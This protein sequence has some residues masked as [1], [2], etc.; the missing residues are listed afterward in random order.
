MMEHMRNLKRWGLEGRQAQMSWVEGAE[1]RRSGKGIGLTL[2][3]AGR[4][5]CGQKEDYE[6]RK[7]CCKVSKKKQEVQVLRLIHWKMRIWERDPLQTETSNS[8][9]SCFDRCLWL[10]SMSSLVHSV[11]WWPQGPPMYK[12]QWKGI[13][14]I[15]PGPAGRAQFS[16]LASLRFYSKLNMFQFVLMC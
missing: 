3:L 12:H 7:T 13:H 1:D 4:G 15:L 10:C 14:H 6:K 5:P 16:I 11:L 8:N 2:F 9:L